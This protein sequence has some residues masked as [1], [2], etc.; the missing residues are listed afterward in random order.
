MIRY[1]VMILK[2][3]PLSLP[4]LLFVAFF[5][6][7]FNKKCTATS[8]ALAKIVWIRFLLLLFVTISAQTFAENFLVVPLRS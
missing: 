2:D 8:V 1:H 6:Q 7:I 5:A 4:P 3:C